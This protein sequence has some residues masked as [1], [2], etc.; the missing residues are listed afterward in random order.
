ML[1]ALRSC[2]SDGKREALHFVC[3]STPTQQTGIMSLASHNRVAPFFKSLG[4]Y[5]K[6]ETGDSSTRSYCN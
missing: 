2:S 1:F 3:C 4:D 6:I 5:L